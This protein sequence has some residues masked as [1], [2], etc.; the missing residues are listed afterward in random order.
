MSDCPRRD[1]ANTNIAVRGVVDEL[2]ENGANA[3]EIAQNFSK[4]IDKIIKGEEVASF[5]EFGE[6]YAKWVEKKGEQT[7][8]AIKRAAVWSLKKVG[9]SDEAA[10]AFVRSGAAIKLVDH[11][12]YNLNTF[13]NR[14]ELNAADNAKKL[15][16]FSKDEIKGIYEYLHGWKKEGELAEH[17]RAAANSLKNI[18]ARNADELVRLGALRAEHR[19]EDYVKHYFAEHAEQQKSAIA[20]AFN[21]LAQDSQHARKNLSKEELEKLGLLEDEFA[22]INTIKEQFIQIEKAKRLKELAENFTSQKEVEGWVRFGVNKKGEPDTAAWGALA[23]RYMPSDMAVALNDINAA[24]KEIGFLEEFL[25][26]IVSHIK[27]NMTAKNPATHVYNF[28]ANYALAAIKG[29]FVAINKMLAMFAG[30]NNQYKAWKRLAQDYGLSVNMDM[31]DE[32]ARK[33]KG[34][35]GMFKKV[36][37][38]VKTPLKNLYLAEGTMLGRAIR[39]GYNFE[40]A[41]FKLAHFKKIMDKAGFDISKIADPAYRK[42]FEGR[43]SSAMKKANYEYVDYAT[44]WNK[45]AKNIDKYGFYPFLQYAWKS[46]PMMMQTMA[47]NPVKFL[48]AMGA[49]GYFGGLTWQNR[50]EK[51]SILPEWAQNGYVTNLFGADSWVRLGNSQYFFNLGRLIPAIRAN[52]LSGMK[53]FGFYKTLIYLLNG[54]TSLGYEYVGKDDPSY[55]R[56]WDFTNEF[57]KSFMPPATFGRYGKNTLELLANSIADTLNMSKGARFS[58][59]KDS[60]GNDLDF[61]LVLLR[62]LGVRELPI[63]KSLQANYN[64]A[65]KNLKKA[66]QNGEDLKEYKEKINQLKATARKEKITLKEPRK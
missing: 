36:P 44:S 25:P 38:W 13:K 60:A 42:S 3:D 33:L 56:F 16:N 35:I 9:I 23:G 61:H 64:K 20:R 34:E 10:K 52:E 4:Q 6:K 26:A 47:K 14:V 58:V 53:E 39:A 48:V 62:A 5:S 15:A 28:A 21:K 37:S 66:Q 11:L 18:I 2:L 49:I 63:K 41:V 43:L 12:N 29:D 57:A 59:I 17:T 31:I 32:G 50:D 45:V 8:N 19:M 27:V 24:S 7:T 22:I 55:K 65:H 46:T 51:N 54:K 30:D 40:D 1:I